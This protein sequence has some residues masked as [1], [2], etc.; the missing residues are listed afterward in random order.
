MLD[1][2]LDL[3][4]QDI[5]HIF[6][7]FDKNNDNTLD[8]NEFMDLVLGELTG[9][10]E[11]VVS[12]AFDKIDNRQMGFVPYAKVRELFDGKKHP[13]VCNGRKTEQEIITDFLEIYEMH[14]N[15]FNDYQKQDK[16]TKPEF[17]EFYKTLSPNYEDDNS[18]ISMVKGVWGVKFEQPDVSLRGTAGGLD[19]SAN[20][21]DRY[22]KANNKGTPFGTSNNENTSQWNTSTQN[23]YKSVTQ[24]QVQSIKSS[25][26]PTKQSLF[27]Q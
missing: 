8:I 22:Q 20:S 16:V 1:F 21:R 10:R 7:T 25:G 5:D 3:E 14:H 11:A 15:T 23:N 2:K 4:E 19:N 24:A 13:D 18:F 26:N 12:Q 9:N 27:V 17:L 6:K